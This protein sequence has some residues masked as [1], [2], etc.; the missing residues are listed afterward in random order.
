MKELVILSG[1]GGTGK[2]TVTAALVHLA[3][4]E[5]PP[6]RIV[7]TDADVDAANLA[8]LLDPRIEEEHAFRSGKTARIDPA[9]CTDCG[10]CATVCRFGAVITTPVG[11]PV[12]IDPLAC[13]GCAACFYA[14]PEAAISLEEETTGRLLRS[15]T[16]RGPLFHATLRPAA[17]NSGKLVMAV[18]QMARRAAE[19]DGCD[20]MLTDGPP[21]IGCPVVSSITGADA[22]L[23]VAEPGLAG[24]HDLERIVETVRHFKLPATVCLNKT[25]LYPD[26]TLEI[27]RFCAGRGL[28]IAGSIPWDEEV[29]RA[30]VAGRPVT[31][32]PDAP[33][34]RAL[35]ALWTRL[36]SDLGL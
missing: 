4:S 28:A 18:R 22:T 15:A 16:S 31:A 20:L 10:S 36:R 35:S 29:I 33:A 17:E 32:T 19:A 8:L 9:I 34:A 26:G 25:D 27:E 3:A 7:V 13:E 5:R 12:E 23:I 30:V 24:I 2:T 6:L 21:G 11:E 1:K 14:C